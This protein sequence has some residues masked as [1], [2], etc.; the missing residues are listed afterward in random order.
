MGGGGSGL[1][2]ALCTGSSGDSTTSGLGGGT[3]GSEFRGSCCPGLYPRFGCPG[4]YVGLREVS[5]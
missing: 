1:G 4:L 2:A 3:G 5:P